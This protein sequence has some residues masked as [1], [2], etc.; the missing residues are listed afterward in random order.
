KQ[1][2][3]LHSDEG[4]HLQYDFDNNRIDY[5]RNQI[6]KKEPLVRALGIEKGIQ[7]VLDL[8][9]GLAIDSVLLSQLGFQ[10]TSLERNGI[11][12][13]L[14][15]EGQKVSLRPE[16]QR[17]QFVHSQAAS[18]LESQNLLLDCSIYFDPMFPEKKK[19]ALPRQEMQFFKKLVGADEDAAQVLKLA[20]EKNVNR[21]VVKRPI[22]AEPLWGIPSHQL[23]TKLVRYDV[24][25]KQVRLK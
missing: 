22:K 3:T 24:Y 2:T 14:A 8:S 5:S 6:G 7:K 9:M 20:L 23:K 13:F 12:H 15:I 4:F 16:V 11:L 10:V 19:A 1:P 18:Y 21:V 25:M 17:I